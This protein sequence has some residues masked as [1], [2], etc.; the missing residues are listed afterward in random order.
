MA[1]FAHVG[2]DFHSLL[3]LRRQFMH[4]S[5]LLENATTCH[6]QVR[7]SLAPYLSACA[8][9]VSGAHVGFIAY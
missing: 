1:T 9:L 5:A 6:P 2:F 4:R 3:A 7:G 8:F